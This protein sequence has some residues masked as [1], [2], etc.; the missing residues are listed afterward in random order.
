MTDCHKL[1]RSLTQC[2]LMTLGVYD[3]DVH[4]Q[5]HKLIR[6]LVGT[7]VSHKLI[8]SAC[9]HKLIN[10][11]YHSVIRSLHHKVINSPSH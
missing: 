4:K 9:T 1:M 7:A 2:E 5:S 11:Q 8:N 10:T 6:S 3:S